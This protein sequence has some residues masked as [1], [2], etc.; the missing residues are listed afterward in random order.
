MYGYVNVREKPRSV[1]YLKKRNRIEL[2]SSPPLKYPNYPIPIN[3][4]K[5][6]DLRKLVND[7]VPREY[8]S[9]YAEMRQW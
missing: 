8:Q 7:Y 2:D 3:K 6:E 9:F 4:A 1:S 5:A